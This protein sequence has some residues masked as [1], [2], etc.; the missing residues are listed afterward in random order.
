MPQDA[1]LKELY[2]IR[3]T[4]DELIE[5]GLVKHWSVGEVLGALLPAV[6]T[7]LGA[8]GAFVETYGED[9]ALHL[10][11]T[12][13]EGGKPLSIP[14][15]AEVFARTSEDTRERVN[16]ILDG[17]LVIAQ[18]LDVAGE[19]FGRAG[20]VCEPAGDTAL[21]GDALE[22]VSEVLDNYLFAI[23]ASRAKHTVMMRLGRALRHRVLG[24]GVKEAVKVLAEA[25]PMERMVLVYV[26]EES[27]TKTLHVQMFNGGDLEVDT[28]AAQG[29]TLAPL[30]SMG[31]EYLNGTN[32]DLLEH[33]G[34]KNASEEVLINGIKKSVVVGKVVVTSKTPSFNTYDRELLSAFA[35]YIRQRIVDFNKEWRALGLAFRPDDVG[36]LLQHDDYEKR[37]LAPREE[38]VGVVYIDISG[39][40]K[41]SETILKT[42][43]KVAELV[44]A[45]SRDA[46]DIVWQHGGVF[47]KMVGDCVIALFGPPFYEET[48]GE[49]LARAIQCAIDVRAMTHRVPERVA[50]EMLRESGLAVSTGVH[51]AP[52]FVGQFGPNSNFTGFSSGMNNTARLQGCAG[53]DEILVMEEAI[54]AL[55]PDHPFKFSEARAMPVKNVAKPLRFRALDA[56]MIAK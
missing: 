12:H 50:F 51:L 8:R 1:H 55:C 34:V 38:T 46:V 53:P 56:P 26:A 52:L 17:S 16:A 29:Q 4:V 39:F 37:F 48:P 15:K 36:R 35:G 40:T 47:D 9:L 32:D 45:W 54:F 22:A 3:N 43:A 20:L 18:H 31:R 33:L 23:K 30:R 11:T 49:R 42:P 13:G 27:A 19:W 41:V 6:V 21:L 28:L 25:I 14:S 2:E 5:Q 24:E 10:F 44:E 7:R